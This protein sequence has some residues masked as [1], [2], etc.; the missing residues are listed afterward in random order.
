MYS[1]HESYNTSESKL[2]HELAIHKQTREK[3]KKKLEKE[4]ET[5]RGELSQ[6]NPREQIKYFVQQFGPIKGRKLFAEWEESENMKQGATITAKSMH[7]KSAAFD[8]QKHKMPKNKD[9]DD[10]FN[11]QLL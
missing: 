2:L 6:K 10:I 4:Y 7:D 11:V 1:N 8:M 5:A 3:G 9:D